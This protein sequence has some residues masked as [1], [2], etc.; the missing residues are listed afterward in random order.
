M[1]AVMTGT[2]AKHVLELAPAEDE[3]PVEALVAHAANPALGMCVRVRRLN[4]CVDH[5][6]PS[7]SIKPAP[8]PEPARVI[9]MAPSRTGS[10][11][12]RSQARRS[13][14]S[15]TAAGLWKRP[16]HGRSGSGS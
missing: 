14:R 10:S 9:V 12:R 15:A 3:Q 4:G 13:S 11:L 2:D 7:K 6:D 16:A 1:P 8:G 5:G